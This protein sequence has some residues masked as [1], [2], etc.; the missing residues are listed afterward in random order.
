MSATGIVVAT[1]VCYQLVLLSV[2]YWARHRAATTAGYFIGDRNLG[3]FV[4][5][6][7]YAAG[8]SSAWSILGV[9]GIAF[10]QGL[11]SVW[12]IP[13]TITGHLVVWYWL[14]PRL[15]DAAASGR[16]LTL[17]DL[18]VRNLTGVARRVTYRL[19]ALVIIVSFTFYIAAQFQGAANTF[20]AV[21]QFD[22]H[23]AL[24][25]GAAVVL[26]YTLWGGFWAVSLTDAL[27]A[28]LMLIAA[29]LL[30]AVA[31]YTVGGFKGLVASAEPAH[32]SLLSSH[33]GWFAVGFFLG[34][35]S[36]GFGPLGQ[37]HLLNRIM[38][39][40]DL[41]AIRVARRVAVSWFVVVLGGMYILGLCGHVLVQAASEQVFFVLAESL[42][43][44]VLTGVLIAAVLSAIMSTADSQ[45]LVAG[46]AL[47]HDLRDGKSDQR[48][49]VRAGR[50][51]VFGVALG[52]VLL[53]ALVPES[54]FSR[55][56]FAWNA[57]GAAFGPLVI[58][59]LTGWR[60]A[61]WAAPA[62]IAVGFG[63]TVVFY[64]LPNGPGDIWERGIPFL[65]AALML[66]AARGSRQRVSVGEAGV[67][68]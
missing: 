15:R 19:A 54:I 53:A 46:A 25:V 12:L 17:T 60:G 9:S 13:G 4:A 47:S 36:I 58:A 3:P 42:L 65:A 68:P 34:M 5:S 45:L 21:F 31:L 2:G 48:S 28:L 23:L 39:L 32:L 26:I 24:I 56:L 61:S 63:L 33:Q 22:F 59:Q 8:S 38:A 6:L 14:A 10:S 50:L 51:A 62:S 64:S 16:W 7:S 67:K 37:P 11:G 18:L 20:T 66:W 1:L 27:Q 41:Q 35:L 43:P 57:L 40:K 29:L 52:A 55:V 44:P 49:A 30:P